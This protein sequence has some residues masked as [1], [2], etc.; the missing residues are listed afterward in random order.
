MNQFTSLQDI[1]QTE[2]TAAIVADNASIFG[3][4]DTE[5][6][7]S[8]QSERKPRSD[9]AM[10]PIAA[11]P[12]KVLSGLPRRSSQYQSSG[13]RKSCVLTPVSINKFLKG[14][15]RFHHN[16]FSENRTLY[17]TLQN[18]QAPKTVLIGCCDSRVDPAIITDCDPGDIFV[19]R[20]VA[21]LVAPYSQDAGH[22][23]TAS[24]L[25]YAVKVLKVENIVVLG[26][27]KC[28]GIAALLSQQ[29]GDLE[30]VGPWMSIASKARE[31]TLKYY[32]DKPLPAQQKACGKR[33]GLTAEHASIM[34][35][36]ENLVSYPFIHSRLKD[37]TL[38][39]NGWYFD[40]ESGDLM[41]YNPNS[42]VFEA[43]ADVGSP[44]RQY[45]LPRQDEETGA[46]QG[47]PEPID[48][49]PE[50]AMAN[51]APQGI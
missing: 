8:V 30:F 38:T 28:G 46:A 34:Q 51:A 6:P 36:L 45:R 12:S 9:D 27:S 37:G 10:P 22:H 18:G 14:F 43:I 40:F 24:A 42:S 20:N 33:L 44:I 1:V 26:H 23:G 49:L 7:T 15:Q 31:K 11:S 48:P 3:S 19:V 4:R 35:S 5:R 25:E 21:N 39:L 32:G 50:A 41:A 2:A 29:T 16:Y 17:D 13:S 47:E